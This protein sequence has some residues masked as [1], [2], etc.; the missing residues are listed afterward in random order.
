MAA[1]PPPAVPA[2]ADSGSSPAATIV[3][4]VPDGATAGAASKID[5]GGP[6]A[7]VVPGASEAA[8]RGQTS[9]SAAGGTGRV[10]TSDAGSSPGRGGG[11][12]AGALARAA[13]GD[14]QGGGAADYTRY[15]SVIRQRIQESLQYPA[16]ARRRGLSGTVHL[17]IE[18][19]PSGVIARVAVIASSSHRLL[20]EAAL[21]AARALPRIPFPGDL[22]PRALRARLPI[23]FELR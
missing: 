4:S 14:G 2:Q 18:V 23:V 11:L 20:D 19:A 7:L 3:T 21:E 22:R 9:G 1:A 15:L 16:S 6:T 5:G 10:V 13:P 8:G 17:E 12:G